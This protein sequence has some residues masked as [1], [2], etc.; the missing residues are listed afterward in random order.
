[1]P[2]FELHVYFYDMIEDD[3]IKYLFSSKTYNIAI[4][5]LNIKCLCEG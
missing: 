4:N 1:M 2:M 3:L 5:N